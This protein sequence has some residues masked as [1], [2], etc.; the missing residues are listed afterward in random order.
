M[1]NLLI[2]AKKSSGVERFFELF[3]RGN[4]R[5]PQDRGLAFTTNFRMVRN[6]FTAMTSRNTNARAMIIGM[7]IISRR[8]G[9]G[10]I[11]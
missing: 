5:L 10:R 6:R 3:L 9:H 7:I 4:A 2:F 11:A 1:I 8:P